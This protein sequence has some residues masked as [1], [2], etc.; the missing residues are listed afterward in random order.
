MDLNNQILAPI[1]PGELIDKITI[2]NLKKNY[3]ESKDKLNNVLLELSYLKDIQSKVKVLKT[4][5]IIDISNKLQNVN[6]Q[7]WEVEDSLRKLESK[8]NFKDEFIKLARSVYHFND[9]RAALKREI[10]I[11]CG[12]KIV[13]EKSYG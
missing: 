8:N 2:L 3:F 6:N 13:E 9:Q 12:S 11:L 4:Q 5:K 10:N 1:S 7:L